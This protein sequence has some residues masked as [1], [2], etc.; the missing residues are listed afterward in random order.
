MTMTQMFLNNIL[1]AYVNEMGL[2]G[3]ALTPVLWDD[4]TVVHAFYPLQVCLSV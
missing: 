2:A 3:H 4:I 1:Y